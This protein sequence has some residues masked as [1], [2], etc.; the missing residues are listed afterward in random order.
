[1]A[2]E[3]IVVARRFHGPPDSGNGGYV[4]GL[5]GVRAARLGQAAEVTLRAPIP[6]DRPLQLQREGDHLALNDGTTPIATAKPAGD[7]RLDVPV[8]PSW[9]EAVACSQHGGSGVESEFHQCF[10]CGAGRKPG[11]GLRV[12]AQHIPARD[13]KPA[14][15][16]AAWQPHDTFAG[17]D[18]TIP[19]EFLWSALDCPGAVAVLS[20]DDE[21]IILTGRM[22]GQVDHLPRSGERCVVAGWAM[23][24]EGRKLYSGTAVVDA[25]GR[26]LARAFI[27][28]IVVRG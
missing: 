6:L 8:L 10:V 25:A 2:F 28:W 11:D 16:L 26:V 22:T 23:G 17:P 1:M 24:G 27:T 5:L 4:S 9:N 19:P 20:D 12:L 3:P 14:M 18:G 15:A 7:F 21:R 13:G